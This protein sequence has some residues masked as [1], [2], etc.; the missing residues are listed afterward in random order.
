MAA[1]ASIDRVVT[2]GTFTGDGVTQDVEN[3][4]W[5]VGDDEVVLVVDA[6]HDVG[7][8]RRGVG[9]RRV[10]EIACT[11]GHRDHVD[12][13]PQLAEALGAATLL[14]PADRP[15]W[16]L[17]HDVTPP[18]GDLVEGDVLRIAHLEVR[19]LETPGHS[20][21]S[22][23][24]YVPAL[25]AVFTGDTLFA[26]GPRDTG[27]SLA[28]FPTLVRS[29]REKL[30]GLPPQTRILPGHGEETTIGAEAPHLDEWRA[31]AR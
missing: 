24:L 6:A 30:L 20:P 23:C 13:A 1:P 11:H 8:I 3:N 4:V 2:T 21:G 31:R 27:R 19:V 28:V 17:T 16:D 10:A 15:L 12:V 18:D 29:I 26:G 22:I 25:D 7:A 14:H 5:L 9:G